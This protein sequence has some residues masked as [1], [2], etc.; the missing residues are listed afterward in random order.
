MSGL[1]LLQIPGQ[2]TFIGTLVGRKLGFM[3]NEKLDSKWTMHPGRDF[4]NMK[5][6]FCW[7]FLA[8]CR[9]TGQTN[10][11]LYSWL[12]LFFSAFSYFFFVTGNGAKWSEFMLKGIVCIGKGSIWYIH[13]F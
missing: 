5:K 1:E 13:R 6:F 11:R 10:S 8:A 9:L 3:V 4:V 12:L 7:I 2:N